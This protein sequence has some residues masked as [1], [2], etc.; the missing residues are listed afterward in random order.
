MK[1]HIKYYL[2]VNLLRLKSMTFYTKSFYLEL[3]TDVLS[4]VIA[5]LFYQVL[6]LNVGEGL[7]IPI[8]DLFILVLSVKLTGDLYSLL[9][10]SGVHSLAGHIQYG[11]L[12]NILIKP[13]NLFFNLF[14][15]SVNWR[16]LVNLAIDTVLFIILISRYSIDITALTVF[17]YLLIIG[18]ATVVYTSFNILIYLGSIIFVRL[19][20][21]ASLISSFF[22]LSTFPAAIFK[23]AYLKWFFIYVIPVL[24]I[25][26]FPLLALKGMQDI[27]FYL[28]IIFCVALFASLAYL[29]T[30]RMLKHYKSASS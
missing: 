13:L 29:G 15:S 30:M 9:F 11:T 14:C 24:V 8:A 16:S 19:D 28:T 1:H 26:N 5:L 23:S 3:I 7:G 2:K 25:G 27:K 20:A 6:Y 4:I 22:S 21:F 10:A 12:D 17:N 18:L